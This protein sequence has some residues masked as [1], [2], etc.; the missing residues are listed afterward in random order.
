MRRNGSR[1]ARDIK[2]RIRKA[3]SAFSKKKILFANRLVLK[4]RRLGKEIIPVWNVF[5]C[6]AGKARRRSSWTNRVKNE[7]LRRVRKERNIVGTIKRRK[8]NWISH[9]LVRTAFS[10]TLLKGKIEATGRRG[11]RRK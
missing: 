9:I 10:N 8:V 4:F 2:S 11:R 6:V 7:V 3:K 1:W 5:I